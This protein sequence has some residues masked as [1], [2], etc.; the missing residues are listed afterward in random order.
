MDESLFSSA[1]LRPTWPN[2]VGFVGLGL[3]A[4]SFQCRDRVK[5]C[6]FLAAG[7]A[8]MTAHY[9]GKDAMAA[10]AVTGTMI[11]SHICGAF[12]GKHPR[13][14]HAKL[15]LLPVLWGLTLPFVGSWIDLLP[16]IA[17]TVEVICL[18]QSRVV[19]VRSGFLFS[20]PLFTIFNIAVQSG[21]GLLANALILSS[22]IIGLLRFHGP[23]MLSAETKDRSGV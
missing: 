22:T 9:F 12:A 10:A 20:Q 2:L 17:V 18:T 15:V 16:P 1:F 3:L 11:F 7:T 8:A 6:L 5:V 4:V 13:L 23:G 14:R 19:I 21:P